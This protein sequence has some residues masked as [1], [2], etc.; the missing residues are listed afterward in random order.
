MVAVTSKD[1][2]ACKKRRFRL[3]NKFGE[4]SGAEDLG[5]SASAAHPEDCCLVPRDLKSH[6]SLYFNEAQRCPFISLDNELMILEMEQETSRRVRG[7]GKA[8]GCVLCNSG[9]KQVVPPRSMSPDPSHHPDG[10]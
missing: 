6:S 1:K 4:I 3:E 9:L 7:S 8:V 5:H 2:S 10:K